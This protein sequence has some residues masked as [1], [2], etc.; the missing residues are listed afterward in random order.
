VC[1]AYVWVG[2]RSVDKFVL[3]HVER[4]KKVPIFQ[5]GLRLTGAR[6]SN[7]F[8]DLYGR[9]STGHR[10]CCPT[11]HRGP[12]PKNGCD[13]MNEGGAKSSGAGRKIC[14]WGNNPERTVE[15]ER[16]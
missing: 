5:L 1:F 11:V 6:R 8:Q 15:V 13:A 16:E 2:K 3:K 12:G 4:Q 10:T 7:P 14:C 9:S